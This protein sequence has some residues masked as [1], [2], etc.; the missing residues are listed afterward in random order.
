M[1]LQMMLK[2]MV[3]LVMLIMAMNVLVVLVM[4]CGGL[5]DS[6]E[7][8]GNHSDIGDSLVQGGEC[9]NV[10]TVFTDGDDGVTPLRAQ[11]LVDTTMSSP[12]Q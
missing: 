3:A 7:G 8:D 6:D 11:T 4:L 12:P 2:L 5:D 10:D 9:D 1:H